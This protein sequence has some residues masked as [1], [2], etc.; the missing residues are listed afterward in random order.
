M[1]QKATCGFL[2]P[3]VCETN[4]LFLLKLITIYYPSFATG[5]ALIL[6][7]LNLRYPIW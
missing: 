5:N 4:G 2:D 6:Y 7:E 3:V 1:L